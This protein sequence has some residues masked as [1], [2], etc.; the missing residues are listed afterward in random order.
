[1]HE[2]AHIS[3]HNNSDVSNFVDDLELPYSDNNYEQEADNLADEALIPA[4]EWAISPARHLNSAEAANH[5]ADRLQIHP[6]IVAGK[7]QYTAK[8]Y[9][10]L[11]NLVGRGTVRSGTPRRTRSFAISSAANT[12]SSISA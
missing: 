10:I 1:M 7:M 4:D 6:A 9:R 3:L 2:L 5:L 8:S 11:N 12:T